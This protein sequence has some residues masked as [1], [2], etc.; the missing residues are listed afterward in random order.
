MESVSETNEKKFA[1][2]L[3]NLAVRLNSDIQK[4]ERVLA[5]IFHVLRDNLPYDK[6][7]LIYNSLPA[8]MKCF[9]IKG[10]N[11]S[12]VEKSAKKFGDFKNQVLEGQTDHLIHDLEKDSEV[13]LSFIVVFELFRDLISEYHLKG[14]IQSLPTDMR[15]YLLD[16][17]FRKQSQ[18][19]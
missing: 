19:K 3:A 6:A 4:A 7:I 8:N 18:K 13:I 14:I 16:A 17:I 10:W 11:K 2:T 1:E 9:Y 5:N 15:E 12:E